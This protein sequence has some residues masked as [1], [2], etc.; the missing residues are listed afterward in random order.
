MVNPPRTVRR[1]P[2]HFGGRGKSQINEPNLEGRIEVEVFMTE[3]ELVFEV[4]RTHV[5]RVTSTQGKPPFSGVE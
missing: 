4:V 2:L 3:D 5:G 1:G